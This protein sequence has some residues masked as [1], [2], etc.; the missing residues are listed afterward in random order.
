L[1]IASL[2]GFR[3]FGKAQ[4]EGVWLHGRHDALADKRVLVVGAGSVGRAV[5]D[6]LS[7]FEVDIV[8][9][10]RRARA[11]L[12][13]VSELPDL[14]P[15]AD[16][17]VL[18]VP[19]T[20]ATY[21]LVDAAFLRVMKSGSLLVNVSRGSVVD[22]DALL[23]ELDSGRLRAALDV[24]DP[25]PLP[26]DHPLWRAPNVMISPHVGGDTSAFLPRAW[27]LVSE[28]LTRFVAHDQLLHVVAGPSPGGRG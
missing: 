10:A 28:Q 20:D 11:D 16:V 1:M 25:E 17:V 9:V 6:R 23:R 13:A 22:T 2:R 26:Y 27:R 4:D 24:T 12:H 8:M 18:T 7:G 19:L 15:D 5:A 21:K 14:L 3:G